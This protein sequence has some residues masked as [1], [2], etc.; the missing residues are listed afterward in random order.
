MC[1]CAN[2]YFFTLKFFT[3]V[4]CYLTKALVLCVGIGSNILMQD[5]NNIKISDFGVA[6]ILNTLSQANT[7][8]KGTISWMAPEMFKDGTHKNKVDIW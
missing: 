2:I 8:G 3:F 6:K 1:V 5:E 4:Y 7:Q